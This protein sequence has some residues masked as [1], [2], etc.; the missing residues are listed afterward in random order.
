M[1]SNM[2]M[3]ADLEGFILAYASRKLAHTDLEDLRKSEIFSEYVRQIP[4]TKPSVRI[5]FG[6]W[7]QSLSGT[8]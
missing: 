2:K 7:H 1:R 3:V 8:I 6:I 5:T 4:L